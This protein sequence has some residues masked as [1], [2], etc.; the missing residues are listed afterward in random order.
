M[1]IKKREC[2]KDL[3]NESLFLEKATASP[4]FAMTVL[5][6]SLFKTYNPFCWLSTVKNWRNLTYFIEVKPPPPTNLRI[7]K[8]G[9]TF[10]TLSWTPPVN[11]QL[12]QI[13][14]FIISWRRPGHGFLSVLVPGAVS[15]HQLTG[16]KVDTRYQFQVASRSPFGDGVPSHMIEGVTLKGNCW[17]LI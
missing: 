5:K 7:T 17:C 11:H 1:M 15:S 8:R 4:N 6:K 2:Q 16:L 13:E 3:S 12:Y 10:L 14:H 9:S